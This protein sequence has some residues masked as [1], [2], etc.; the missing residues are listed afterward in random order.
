MNAPTLEP[1][2]GFNWAKVTWGRPDSR[3]DRAVL[4][5]LRRRPRRRRSAHPVDRS[6]LLG[7]VLQTMPQDLVGISRNSTRSSTHERAALRPRHVAV[8]RR[9]ACGLIRSRRR[10]STTLIGGRL[11]YHATRASRRSGGRA[12]AA[13]RRRPEASRFV[14]EWPVS[15]EEGGRGRS[16]EPFSLTRQGVGVITVT[17]TLIN[18]GAFVGSYSG[19][20]SYEGIK[21]QLARAAADSP[22]NQAYPRSRHAGRRGQRRASKRRKRCARWRRASR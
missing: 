6:G 5:L 14:G 22:V 12:L 15:E 20:T 11:G 1:K 9:A 17:G 2:A 3:A 18:R 19:E 8:D 10:S 4:L 7:A 21:H 16:I 13:M